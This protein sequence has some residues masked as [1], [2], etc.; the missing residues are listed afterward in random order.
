[1]V[2]RFGGVERGE[3]FKEFGEGKNEEKRREKIKRLKSIVG[4]D[5]V[6]GS[7]TG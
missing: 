2:K 3:F 4:G 1:M 6:A 7:L 5:A